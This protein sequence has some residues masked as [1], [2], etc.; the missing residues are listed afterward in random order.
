MSAT[1][2]DVR[3]FGRLLRV[4]CPQEQQ[5]ALNIAAGD[6][7]QRLQNLKDR[8]HVLNTE[9]LLFITALNVCHELTQEK[10]KTQ[11][12]E[13]K[14]EQRIRI[15]LQTI[16]QALLAQSNVSLKLE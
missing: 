4:N 5:D 2:V 8:T 7:N 11:N 9:T 14:I 15:L 13:S 1:L 10:L 3:I 12:H 6:L 16:E